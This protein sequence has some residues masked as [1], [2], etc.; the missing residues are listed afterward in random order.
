MPRSDAFFVYAEVPLPA[1]RLETEPSA[2]MLSSVERSDA[3]S[4][5]PERPSA[6]S[7]FE[8]ERSELIFCAAWFD[9]AV[10]ADGEFAAAVLFDAYALFEEAV[11]AA[12]DVLAAEA[13]FDEELAADA[14]DDVL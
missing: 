2:P 10:P 11:L 1:S 7:A 4:D 3:V 12:E 5:V 6:E 9:A 14:E 13:L 8:E